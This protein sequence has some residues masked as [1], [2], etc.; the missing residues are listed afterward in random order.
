MRVERA[1][2]GHLFGRQRRLGHE[3]RRV[4]SLHHQDPRGAGQVD[5][6]EGGRDDLDH[7]GVVPRAG[8]PGT[9]DRFG[10]L[11]VPDARRQNG[12]GPAASLHLGGANGLSHRAATQVRRAHER[13]GA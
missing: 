12:D 9:L 2:Q 13:N 10:S 6:G 5:L 7:R 1:E 8:E 4:S 3:C 11:E